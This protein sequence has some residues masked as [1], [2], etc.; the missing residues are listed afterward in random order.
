MQTYVND[1]LPSIQSLGV[2]GYW[3]IGLLAFGEALVLTSIFAPGT[4]VVVLGGALVAQGVYD[5]GDMIWFV[6]IGTTLGAEFSFRIGARGTNLFQEGRRVFSPS[7]LQRG[8]GFFA[9]YGAPSIIFGHFFGPLRPIVPVVAGLSGM[10]G[11]RFFVWNVIGGFA[12]AIALLSVGYFFGTTVDL[13]S[14]TM[15]RGGLFAIAVIVALAML[16]FIAIKLRNAL[17]FFV[18]VLRSVGHAI[19]DNPDVQDLV[20]R[21]PILF[22]FLSDR[23]SRQAF[24]GLPVTIL[25]SAF[26][27]FLILYA[28]STLDFYNQSQIVAVDVRV[29]NLLSA[30]RDP[31]LTRF[32]TLATAL[33]SWLSVTILAATVSIVLLLRRRLHYLPGLW[34][35]LIGNQLTVTLLKYVFARPRPDMAVYAESSFSFPS[36]HSAASIAFFGFLTY[37]L[38]R[39]R[40]GPIFV[41][42]LAGATVVLLIGLSRIYLVEHYLSDVL[43]GYL[44]GVLWALLGIWLAEWL[45]SKRDRNK[46]ILIPFWRNVAAIA[47]LASA[48]LAVGV[49]VKDYQQTLNIPSVVGV[50]Q[51]KE[52]VTA[53]FADG[54]LPSHSENILGQPQEPISLIILAKDEAAFLEAFSKAGWQLADRP[55]ISTLSRA[56]FAVWFSNEYDTA[57]ITPAF[58]NGQPHDFGFQ[59][60][61]ADK[62]LRERHHA[63]FWRSGFRTADG[64]AIFL[65]TASFDVG[66]KWGLTHRIDPNIDA[67]R[68]F[69]ATG[70]SDTGLV[71]SQERIQLAAPVLGQNL[72]GDPFFTDGKAILLRIGADSN[73]NPVNPGAPMPR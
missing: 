70:L 41:S 46:Q 51:L 39:E 65:G 42:F 38:V 67:E 20:A 28:G 24:T 50:E 19:K 66:L 17:P 40:V 18:S 21:Y 69:L 8:Q 36:G 33:G 4:V 68:D 53:A 62:S 23:L 32:F 72:T 37:L 34:L 64:Q 59:A 63:R 30:F 22:S 27:Y 54:R 16:W 48:L 12:Y 13:F 58:W 49:F 44:V 9:R 6:A 73:S 14:A 61:T 1:L 47:A 60:E 7:V 26:V 11:R 25:A 56:A 10:S 2:W 5:F 31:N 3:I 57:P 71:S 35:S 43:N 52:P 29:A 45:H 55:G 15:T